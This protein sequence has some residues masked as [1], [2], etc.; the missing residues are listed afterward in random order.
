MGQNLT[1][2]FYNCF[3]KLLFTQQALGVFLYL[4][5][6]SFGDCRGLPGALKGDFFIHCDVFK[7][8]YIITD[9]KAV[10]YAE[11]KIHSHFFLIRSNF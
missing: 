1:Q 3:T 10:F 5:M 2:A 9:F 7:V 11:S 8:E 6:L 4:K